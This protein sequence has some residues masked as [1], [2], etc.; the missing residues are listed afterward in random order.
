MIQLKKAS[1]L[2]CA[3][4]LM[5]SCATQKKAVTDSGNNSNSSEM[6]EE[7]RMLTFVQKV[8]NNQQNTKNIVGNVSLTINSD[9]KEINVPG[10]LHMRKDEVIRLQAF[11]PILGS[12]LG[13]IEFTPDRVLLI[14]RMHKEYVEGTYDQM[15][16]L[17]ANGLSFYSLQSMFW[18]QLLLPGK[19][20]VTDIDLHDYH[21]DLTATGK[22]PVSLKEQQGNI[23]YVWDAE[24]T[25]G[26]I[27]AA[28]V[29][30]AN[31]RYSSRLDWT[32]GNFSTVGIKPFPTLQ[33][34]L[35]T[36]TTADGQG[37]TLR[38][39]LNMSE[40]TTSDKWEARTQVSSKFKKVE[41]EE[42]L[43]KLSQIQ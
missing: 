31:D 7:M 2:F 14:D 15:S 13:R 4:L 23:S 34:L 33:D 29:G 36:I 35:F 16:F 39:T 11:I 25:N 19:E 20:H 27:D 10:S 22:R 24:P 30:Y 17:K 8:F 38:L 43:K 21:V 1:I 40:V 26:R 12:E 32:Y 18:N 3:L 42:L 5:A 37:K 9:G 6:T 41:A 28:H